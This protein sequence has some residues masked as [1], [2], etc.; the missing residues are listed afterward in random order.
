MTTLKTT[1]RP[2]RKKSAL[3]KTPLV[4]PATSVK[5][6]L[7][8]LRRGRERLQDQARPSETSARTTVVA[9]RTSKTS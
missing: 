9:R 5:R 8:V 2:V 3:V 1:A 4:G 7:E 6:E